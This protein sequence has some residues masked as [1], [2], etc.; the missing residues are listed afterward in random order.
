[1]AAEEA[2]TIPALSITAVP[3]AISQHTQTGHINTKM[4]ITI[5]LLS[6]RQHGSEVTGQ[7]NTS[8]AITT[9]RPSNSGNTTPLIS[10]RYKRDVIGIGP[11]SNST[12]K[13]MARVT[14]GKR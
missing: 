1:M 7:N 3:N 10:I 11:L 5:R 8:M 14:F 12:D 6:S 2:A 9:R 4:A 13:T